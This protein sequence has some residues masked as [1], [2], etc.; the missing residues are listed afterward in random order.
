MVKGLT[1]LAR[2][3]LNFNRDRLELRADGK[4]IERVV[5]EAD[6]L[7]LSLSAFVRM[8]INKELN[9]MEAESPRPKGK[10]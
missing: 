8:A 2:K 6:R 10:K 7:G 3:R 1:D 4:W 9:R 5:Q